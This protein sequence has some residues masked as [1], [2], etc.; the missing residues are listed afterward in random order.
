MILG[1]QAYLLG[2]LAA[3]VPIVIHL[4]SKKT[5]KTIPFGTIRFL[6]EDDT[7]AIKSLIPTEW[8]LL[9]LRVL[10]LLV[11]VII[12]SEP[13]WKRIGEEADLVLIDPDYQDHPALEAIVDSLSQE[14]N[15]RW[16]TAG[17]P[18]IGDSLNASKVT[19]WEL[20]AVLEQMPINNITVISPRRLS[21]YFGDKP[22]ASNASWVSLPQDNQSFE[23]GAVN[24]GRGGVKITG[25]SEEQVTYFSQHLVEES[26]TDSLLVTVKISSDESFSEL[27]D[28]IKAAIEAINE[29]SPL[30]IKLV[31]ADDADW[32]IWLKNGIVP[33]RRKLIFSH[34]KPDQQI[35]REVSQEVYSIAVFQL[36]AFLSYNF[37]LRLEQVLGAEKIDIRDY[38]WRVLP[39][40][41]LPKKTLNAG[42]VP[43][44][45]ASSLIPWFW[46]LL[47]LMLLMERY[48]S[49]KTTTVE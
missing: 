41:Q 42:F 15:V 31:S 7:Q 45:L 46:G 14:T 10:I 12:M 40:T 23:L 27:S 37:P 17:Y 24:S 4:W 2:I 11:L 29:D 5:R 39:Q 48:L 13:L 8:F 25:T 35:I 30:Q 22:Q 33:E 6:S 16:F 34:S 3:L 9:I 47:L 32:L 36:E 1:T 18:A 26:L 49:L 43:L 28:F 20:L 38:D 44:E 19:H 21:N